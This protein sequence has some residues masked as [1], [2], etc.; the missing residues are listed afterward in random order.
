MVKE[1]LWDGMVI[2]GNRYSKSTFGANNNNNNIELATK[3]DNT[4]VAQNIK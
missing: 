4:K 1:A 3:N 2:L